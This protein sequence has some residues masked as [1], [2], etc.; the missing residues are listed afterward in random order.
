[1][2][3]AYRPIPLRAGLSGGNS[4]GNLAHRQTA[5]AKRQAEH[6]RQD[7]I[8]R[9]EALDRGLKRYFTGKSCKRGHVAERWTGNANCVECTQAAHQTPQ[10]KEYMR[11][12]GRRRG[13][14]AIKVPQQPV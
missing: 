12:Y 13:L 11:L 10:H 14:G 8:T 1:M 4:G 5:E 2:T 3:I 9:R 7:Q 6:M